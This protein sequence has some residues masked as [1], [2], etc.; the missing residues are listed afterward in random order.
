MF[1]VHGLKLYIYQNLF[2]AYCQK[3]SIFHLLCV[4]DSIHDH[5]ASNVI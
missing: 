4:L 5:Y 3:I 1:L 2:R